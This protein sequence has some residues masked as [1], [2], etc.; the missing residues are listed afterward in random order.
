M[1][2]ELIQDQLHDATLDSISVSTLFLVAV[3]SIQSI[4]LMNN[5][6]RERQRD[7][8]NSPELKEARRE[9]NKRQ[10]A[11]RDPNSFS[12]W[13]KNGGKFKESKGTD[14]Y[15]TLGMSRAAKKNY[16]ANKELKETRAKS[17]SSTE[18]STKTRPDSAYTFGSIRESRVSGRTTFNAYSDPKL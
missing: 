16:Y 12:A 11:E 4:K 2:L 9:F 18:S 3:I 17:S 7:F 10:R 5:S 6:A 15:E 8:K 13:K 14:K 1:I